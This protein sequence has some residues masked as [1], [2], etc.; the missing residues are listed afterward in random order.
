MADEVLFPVVIREIGGK[1][2]VLALEGS[3][4]PRDGNWMSIGGEQRQAVHWYA[5]SQSPTVHILGPKEDPIRLAGRFEDRRKGINGHAIAQL[6]IADAMRREGRLAILQWGPFL[7]RVAWVRATFL[8][9]ELERVDYVIELMPVGTTGTLGSRIMGAIKSIPVLGPL[10]EAA[11]V[12]VDLARVIPRGAAGEQLD[13]ILDNIQQAG[14]YVDGAEGVL[15]QLPDDGILPP[16]S[17]RLALSNID[18]AKD[19]AGAA[20]SGLDGLPKPAAGNELDAAFLATTVKETRAGTVG[21]ISEL[22]RVRPQLATLA[23]E[24]A[25]STVYVVTHGDTLQQL[26]RRFYGDAGKWTQIQQFNALA[27]P[28]LSAG[29]ILTIPDAR[30]LSAEGRAP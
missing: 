29:Q 24:S 18:A 22:Q 30:A 4:L 25:R 3:D 21:L 19:S 16:A 6:F 9:P 5:G 13:Q 28:G 20:L 1:G 27:N 26:A 12:V 14:D 7:R 11:E 2:R 23:A 10:V 15:D 8:T 17:A